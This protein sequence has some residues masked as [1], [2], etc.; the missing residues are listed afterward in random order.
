[1]TEATRTE[2]RKYEFLYCPTYLG[3]LAKCGNELYYQS[4]ASLVIRQL[5]WL[6]WPNKLSRDI[7]IFS[8]RFIHI[9]LLSL[10]C[11]LTIDFVVVFTV[12]TVL[13]PMAAVS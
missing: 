10:A 4:F 2:V 7:Q 11:A 13:F 1:M 9:H 3:H 5:T 8:F 6:L 12:A